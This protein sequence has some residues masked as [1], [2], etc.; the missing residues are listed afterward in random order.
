MTGA[1]VVAG[2]AGLAYGVYV[3]VIGVCSPPGTQLTGH[4]VLQPPFK[5]SMAALL[6]L[7]A[8]AHPIVCERRW[9]VPA[10]L[11]C[12]SGDWLLAIPWWALSFIVGL[13]SFL[14][15]HL[16]FLGALLPH[17]MRSKPSPVRIAAVALMIVAAAALLAWF[18]PHLGQDKLTIPVAVYVVVLCAMVCTA[19]LAQLPTIWTAVGTVCFAASDTMIAISRFILGN[20]TLA[21][22]IWWSYAAAAI[23]MTAGLFFGREPADNLAVD[24]PGPA[25]I[26]S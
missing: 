24:V 2:W 15:A 9:L 12:G 8:I 21:V 5:A 20:E 23:L 4:W 19:F 14:V 22:P 17:V 3:A 10:L 11:F 6:A 1:W 13:A 26:L 25:V 16:C 7:A 18:W